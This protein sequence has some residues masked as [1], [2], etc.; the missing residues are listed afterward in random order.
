[1]GR[2]VGQ[3]HWDLLAQAVA[4]K[5]VGLAGA[6]LLPHTHTEAPPTPTSIPGASHP[7]P[8]PIPQGGF[9]PWELLSPQWAPSHVC[10]RNGAGLPARHFPG[11][12]QR[13]GRPGTG[14]PLAQA[15]GAGGS[16]Q[17]PH[18]GPRELDTS[19]YGLL[20]SSWTTPGNWLELQT[21]RSF[22]R[23]ADSESAF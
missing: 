6:H 9:L 12:R 13:W 20:S 22:P 11:Q 4:G 7:P 2:Q 14:L 19:F 8:R 15:W 16:G 21:L 23:P 18:S 1:M 3:V 10:A 5:R 17:R